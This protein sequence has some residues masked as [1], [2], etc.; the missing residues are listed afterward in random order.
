MVLIVTYD[1]HAPGRDYDDIAELLRSARAWAH[2]QGS[3]WWLDTDREPSWWRD[4]LKKRGDANDEYF[5][6]R[7]HQN[8]AGYKMG[9]EMVDWLKS[10]NRTW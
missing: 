3:V 6:A 7:M 2:P 5:V 8:W 1:L 4:E 10:P 9:Q